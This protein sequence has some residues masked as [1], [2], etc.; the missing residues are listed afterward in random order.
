MKLLTIASA[1]FILTLALPASAQK[2]AERTSSAK[3][4]YGN[5]LGG[6]SNYHPRKNKK[7]KSTA[8]KSKK[9]NRQTAISRKRAE[10][11]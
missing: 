2:R 3:A 9:G 5:A 6:S 11:S 7:S 10:K 4:A 1:I 8:K